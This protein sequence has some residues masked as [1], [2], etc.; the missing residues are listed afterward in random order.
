MRKP[1]STLLARKQHGWGSHL[2]NSAPNPSTKGNPVSEEWSPRATWTLLPFAPSGGVH[3]FLQTGLHTRA[4]RGKGRPSLLQTDTPLGSH[5]PSLPPPSFH[6]VR[7]RVPLRVQRPQ[8]EP[9]PVTP[10]CHEGRGAQNLSRGRN[11]VAILSRPGLHQLRDP[12]RGERSRWAT[13]GGGDPPG[14][15]FH[16]V[17]F[18]MA[19]P[20][21]RC[22]MLLARRLSTRRLSL[23]GWWLLPWRGGSIGPPQIA[24]H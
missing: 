17:R 14:P 22:G 6:R 12:A 15:A 20:M 21:V 8:A 2:L 4:A 3:G 1:V 19:A 9:K 24:V 16:L 23:A 7:P 10:G 11:T 13:S 5:A 18:K